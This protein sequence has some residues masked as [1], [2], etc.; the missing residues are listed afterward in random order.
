MFRSLLKLALPFALATGCTALASDDMRAPTDSGVFDGTA[1]DAGAADEGDGASEAGDAACADEGDGALAAADAAGADAPEEPESGG[2]QAPPATLAI[3]VCWSTSDEIAMQSITTGFDQVLT[4]QAIVESNWGLEANLDFGNWPLCATDISAPRWAL[5]LEPDGGALGGALTTLGDADA[6]SLSITFGTVPYP[7]DPSA[8]GPAQEAVGCATDRLFERALGIEDDPA[9]QPIGAPTCG[10]VSA[11]YGGRLSP[12]QILR[13]RERYGPKP[14]GSVV[15][16]DGRCMT[17]SVVAPGG[18]VWTDACSS[19][20]TSSFASNGQQ[21]RFDPW[22]QTLRLVGG[23]SAGVGGAQDATVSGGRAAS[24]DVAGGLSLDGETAA[25]GQNVVVNDAVSMASGQTW[26]TNQVTIRGFAGLC[27]ELDPGT[28]TAVGRAMMWPCTRSRPSQQFNFGGS[29]S[30]Q[31]DDDDGGTDCLTVASDGSVVSLACDGSNPQRWAIADTGGFREAAGAQR[32][33]R[34]V[35]DPA[36]PERGLSTGLALVVVPCS[37]EDAT[38]RFDLMG[39]LLVNQMCLDVD[40]YVR[41]DGTI[42]WTWT[43]GSWDGVPG[44]ENQWWDVLW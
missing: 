3:P 1:S 9:A 42:I 39:R 10:D 25:I 7:A 19:D 41:K 28:S 32:C 5:D 15:A 26:S 29:E 31:I 43:C 36:D 18:P 8:D 13:L 38:Q 24:G 30:I 34:V 23:P 14:R 27:L 20:G 16:F 40:S 2:S 17:A 35:V 22:L 21:W 4:T 37:A 33:L 44:S 12:L 6:G 11:G